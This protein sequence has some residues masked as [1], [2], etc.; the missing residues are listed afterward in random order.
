[1][2][3]PAC[4]ANAI[5]DALQVKDVPLPATPR[6]IHALMEGA[7]APPPAD[8]SRPLRPRTGG[9]R[10]WTM[11]PRPFDYVRPDTVEEAV[12]VLA[13]YGDAARVLAGGQS[14]LAMLNLR[15]VEPAILVDITRI[16]ELGRHPGSR[17]HGRGRCRGDAEPPAGLAGACE[18][19]AACCR[20]PAVR[21]PLPDPQPGHR[22]RLDRP[23]R[24]EF[25]NPART[26]G[27]GRRGR[28]ALAPRTRA[29][30][31]RASSSRT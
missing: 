3:V 14:L 4:I 8:P 22:V 15:L 29:S 9:G 2:S 12:A 20:C 30:C 6:R 13:E 21:R 23:C 28:P 24:S 5:A 16:A 10:G 1:M 17:R 11:K 19:A 27:A 26:R 31:R 7:E 18:Q 25:R